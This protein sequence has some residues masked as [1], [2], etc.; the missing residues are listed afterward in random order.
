M[1]RENEYRVVAVIELINII[2]FA[3]KENTTFCSVSHA[4]NLL[5]TSRLLNGISSNLRLKMKE[6]V[7]SILHA[8]S[9]N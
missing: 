6:R 1:Q 2:V 8:P 9:K 7:I 3:T 5:V 4:E